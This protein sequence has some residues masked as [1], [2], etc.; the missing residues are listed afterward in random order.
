MRDP[1]AFVGKAQGRI[2]QGARK[3]VEFVAATSGSRDEGEPVAK[4]V[5]RAKLV[6][7]LDAGRGD[8]ARAKRAAAQTRPVWTT[9]LSA[10]NAPYQAD[11]AVR[12]VR[13][14]SHR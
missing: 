5:R 12:S 3:P 8:A 14:G 10:C 4:L 1:L 6:T 11:A 7:E 9:L 2:G 13:T